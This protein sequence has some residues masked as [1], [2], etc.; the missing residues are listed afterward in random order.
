M[1]CNECGTE[2]KDGALFCANCGAKLDRATSE[3]QGS[4][5]PQC[6]FENP[7]EGRFCARCGGELKHRHHGL[8]Q[9][10]RQ[11][12]PQEHH[13]RKNERVDTKLKWHPGLVVLA[14]LG[15]AFALIAG[16]ELF[17]KKEPEPPLQIE[18]TISSDRKVETQLNEIASKFVCSCGSCGEQPL[19]TCTCNTAIEE[20]QF[21]RNYLQS[22]Q[23]PEQ[24]IRALNAT[25]GWIE[26]EFTSLVQDSTETSAA[27]IKK[28]LISTNTGLQLGQVTRGA[29]TKLA[30]HADRIEIFSHFSCPCGQ[31][32]VDELKDCNCQHPKGATEVKGYIDGRI[33]E[34]KYTVAQIINE[35]EAKYGGRKV[36]GLNEK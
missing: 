4:R 2:N 9:H 10:H 34:G 7:P 19:E 33:A 13:K 21:I 32:G 18:E 6:G 31:C 29:N 3:R 20:R 35:I 23:T 27:L 14:L 30:T 26:S 22:G 5:C 8:K 28:N 25:Y 15:G 12:A 11:H 1:T 36:Y 16:V 17:V 24:I